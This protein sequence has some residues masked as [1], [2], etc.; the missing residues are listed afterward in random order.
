[1]LWIE[2]LIVFD[3]NSE[4]GSRFTSLQPESFQFQLKGLQSSVFNVLAFWDLKC[5]QS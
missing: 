2:F 1:M 4:F 5:K 3:L